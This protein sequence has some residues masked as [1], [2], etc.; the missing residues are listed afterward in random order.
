[1]TNSGRERHQSV[2][3]KLSKQEIGRMKDVIAL[4]LH[5]EKI[6]NEKE[7]TKEKVI[8]GTLRRQ[9]EASKVV[10]NDLLRQKEKMKE[11]LAARKSKKNKNL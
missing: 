4:N 2:G 11:R 10:D 5:N 8:E 7:G 3:P 6:K 1:M 9:E